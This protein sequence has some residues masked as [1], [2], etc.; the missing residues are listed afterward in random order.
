[1]PCIVHDL[2][3]ETDGESLIT[4]EPGRGRRRRNYVVAPER[5]RSQMPS[6]RARAR[7]RSGCPHGEGME[8]ADARPPAEDT[9]DDVGTWATLLLPARARQM[10]AVH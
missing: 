10:F 7:A 2:P 9:P 3:S 6:W 1:M 8:E 5:N 4:D